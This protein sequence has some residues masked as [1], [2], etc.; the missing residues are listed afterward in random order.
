MKKNEII[1]V[2]LFASISL[3]Y[4]WQMPE[5]TIET[6]EPALHITIYVEGNIQ[7]TVTY[8]YLPTIDDVFRDIG[9]DNI[10]HFDN[11]YVLHDQK[12]LYIPMATTQEVVSLNTATI[13]ELMQVPGIGPKTAASIVQYRTEESFKVI[14]DIMKIQGIGEKTY[15][16]M[17]EYLCL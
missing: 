4:R 8:S 3:I 6:I 17:R 12:V 15:Y 11:S 13:E 9:I 1:A 5:S 7:T 14:E 2:L 10:Y 16:K